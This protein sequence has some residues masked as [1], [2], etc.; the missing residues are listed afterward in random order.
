MPKNL[1]LLRHSKA[2]Q[3]N[4]KLLD[5]HERP[6][7]KLGQDICPFIGAYLG[8]IERKLD[9][10]LCSTALRARSTAE[11]AVKNMSLAKAPRMEQVGKLYLASVDD[12]FSILHEVEDDI[13]SVL[14]VGH[15]PGLHTFAQMISGKGDRKLF[16]DMKS[17]FPP[18][19]LAS[20]ELMCDSWLDLGERKCELK[21]FVT[22]KTIPH[23]DE[24]NLKYGT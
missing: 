19:S 14:L 7:T 21:G 18:A 2:G 23:R 6:L 5:D 17:N 22:P 9:L 11:I 3:T 12:I 4:K 20:F 13:N 24:E 15:N 1:Y 8:D 16:R 10:V